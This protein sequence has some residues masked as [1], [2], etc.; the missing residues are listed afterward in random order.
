MPTVG[1]SYSTSRAALHALPRALV[2]R[3][4]QPQQA[5]PEQGGS[6]CGAAPRAPRRR[7]RGHIGIGSDSVRRL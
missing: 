3:A 6:A 2:P 7:R 4:A 5:E 1:R